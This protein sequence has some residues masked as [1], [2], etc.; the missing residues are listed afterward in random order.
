MTQHQLILD[1]AGVL[2]TNMSPRY[3]EEIAEL[4]NATNKDLKTMFKVH[5]RDSY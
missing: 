1:V 3:W 2:V 4:D 5:L